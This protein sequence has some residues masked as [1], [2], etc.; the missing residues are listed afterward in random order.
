[1]EYLSAQWAELS[2][3]ETVLVGGIV[4]ACAYMIKDILQMLLAPAPSTQM[5]VLVPDTPP[6]KRDWTLAELR[7]FDGTNGKPIYI[8]AKGKVFDMSS[9][10]NFY[11]PGGPY[12]VFAG[13]D[14]SR[15][16]ATM[17]LDLENLDKPLDGLS[18]AELEILDEWVDKYEAAYNNLGP[19]VDSPYFE[20]QKQR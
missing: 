6:V 2:T 3:L 20:G 9:K 15:C 8:S 10:P 19:L 11:G 13:H 18:P 5:P 14:A 16:L 7:E 17:T 4:F 12:G 1:M